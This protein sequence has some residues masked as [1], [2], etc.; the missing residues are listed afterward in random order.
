MDRRRPGDLGER[1]LGDRVPG[2][3]EGIRRDDRGRGHRV[4]VA[5]RRGAR[6][7]L[8]VRRLD[9]DL[10]VDRHQPME[11]VAPF[12]EEVEVHSN[13]SCMTGSENGDM[14]TP[15]MGDSA[16]AAFIRGPVASRTRRST[17]LGPCGT[18]GGD[19]RVIASAFGRNRLPGIG[20]PV[21]A[22]DDLAAPG[23][24]LD[25]RIEEGVEA[26]VLVAA[27]SSLA[28][29]DAAAGAEVADRHAEFARS[30]EAQQEEQRYTV[31]FAV[32][33]RGEHS[34]ER[35]HV[36]GHDRLS[37]ALATS[38]TAEAASGPVASA[39]TSRHRSGSSRNGAPPTMRCGS[40]GRLHRDRS[41]GRARGVQTEA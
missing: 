4:E 9:A 10:L 39:P 28:M 23:L 21:V 6:R 13:P 38:L 29:Q 15:M 40:V 20:R 12:V 16:H 1:P 37:T 14:T 30:V 2:V 18:S 31:G 5:D 25:W 17:G 8:R 3:E 27:P 32:R 22:P 41:G 19:S 26:V 11:E 33:E 34:A 7:Q 35:C 24:D 36:A